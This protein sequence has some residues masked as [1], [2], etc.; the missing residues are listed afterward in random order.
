MN[1]E[2]PP[3]LPAPKSAF[4]TYL[5]AVALLIP[6][7]I[8][9]LFSNIILLPQLE[10]SWEE[11]G[12]K[13]SRPQ[14][15]IDASRSFYDN[16]RFIF[17]LIIILLIFLES[18]WSAWPRYRRTVVMGVTL[19]FHTAILVGVTAIATAAL[20][21][22]HENGIKERRERIHKTA[23][24]YFPKNFRTAASLVSNGSGMARGGSPSRLMESQLMR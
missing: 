5:R 12:F 23:D 6:T 17:L 9:W 22:V 7:I 21:I 15:L 2:T 11:A 19:L 10:Q 4:R 1:K 8:V 20:L 18:R 13:N 3:Q 14:W 16:G 24:F